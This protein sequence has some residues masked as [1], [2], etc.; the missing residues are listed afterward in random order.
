MEALDAL[1]EEP[2]RPPE[3]EGATG[4]YLAAVEEMRSRAS[5]RPAMGPRAVFVVGDADA[6]VP[7]AASPEAANAFLKLLEEPP[8]DTFVVL[9]S[10]RRGALL[11][12]IRSRVLGV[13]VPPVSAEV[14]EAFLRDEAEID[15][16]EAREVARRSQGSIG[17]AL[18]ELGEED[19]DLRDEAVRFV[20]AALADRP[21]RRLAYAAG[22]GPTGARGGY[23][24]L[25]ARVRELLRDV[26]ALS[27]GRRED[28]FDPDRAEALLEGRPPPS[29]YGILRA[30][31]HV[32][33]A[34]DEASGNVNPQGIT[35]VLL[36]EMAKSLAVRESR[37]E[38][39]G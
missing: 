1:R 20:Q 39:T 33:D 10:S 25:L 7:Q 17:R 36:G 9:T 38:R 34:R 22:V 28:A 6:M 11:P 13:R 30:L 3:H 15:P 27:L 21:G 31:E 8:R 23:S 35:A 18:R 37:R 4:I 14:V 5:R 26:L 2:L 19:R 12:T 16:A 24:D 29:P 32:E